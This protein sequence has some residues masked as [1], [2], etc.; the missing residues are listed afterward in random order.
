MRSH[1]PHVLTSTEL[2]IFLTV[3]KGQSMGFINQVKVLVKV[4]IV[5]T[6]LHPML[7]MGQIR[8]L[9]IHLPLTW[10]RCNYLDL[11]YSSETSYGHDRHGQT[12]VPLR[13]LDS[14]P[15]P[16]P[17][18]KFSHGSRDILP[19]VCTINHPPSPLFIIFSMSRQLLIDWIELHRC[20]HH[21][22]SW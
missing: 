10:R 5:H 11:E 21:R 1:L 7:K 3:Q 12:F 20:H 8:T 6:H 2:S 13:L 9:H 22:R 19:T 17:V 18:G 4:W 14:T 15:P 16:C